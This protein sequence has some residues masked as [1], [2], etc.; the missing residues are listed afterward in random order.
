MP[1][2]IEYERVNLTA[3]P[4]ASP[5]PEFSTRRFWRAKTA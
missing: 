4:E 1:I 5:R 3:D 2:G